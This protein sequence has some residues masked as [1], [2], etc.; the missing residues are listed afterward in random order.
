V[1]DPSAREVEDLGVVDPLRAP[2]SL[3][4]VARGLRDLPPYALGFLIA[5]TA[6]TVVGVADWWGTAALPGADVGTSIL[7][8]IV[9]TMPGTVL[10]LIPVAV[11]WSIDR[12][13]G[14]PERVYRGAIAVGLGE[15]INLAT[16][17]VGAGNRPTMLLYG[18]MSLAANFLLAGGLVWIAHGLEA[19]RQ[20]EPSPTTGRGA[21]VVGV[22]GGVGAV[23]LLVL[24]ISGLAASVPGPGAQDVDRALF[25]GRAAGLASALV[26]FGWAYLAWVTIRGRDDLDRD[27]RA[28]R[29]GAVSGWLAG[30]W[31]VASA[32][33]LLAL[34]PSFA[35]SPD[36]L[37]SEPPGGS[38]YVVLSVIGA[39]CRAGAILALAWGLILGLGS[40]GEPE[41]DPAEVDEDMANEGVTTG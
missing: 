25:V 7:S 9:G 22:L 35:G 6:R 11:A 30:A 40:D 33:A 3:G 2:E 37:G 34:V 4:R 23:V 27:P 38:L 8:L 29:A 28:T 10:L 18:A 16:G 21:L 32:I 24:G 13:G 20:R 12:D 19:M 31:L 1:T 36:G 39:A 5:A 14:A 17:F 41:A 26:V 15:L